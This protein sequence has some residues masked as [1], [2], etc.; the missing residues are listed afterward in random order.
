MGK[1]EAICTSPERGT[2][3]F[4]AA[5]AVLRASWGVEGDAHAGDWHRQV[6]LLAKERVDEF[7]ARGAEVSDGAFGENLLTSGLDLQALRVGA[8]LRCGPALLEIT[9]IGKDCHS[10]C[11]IYKRVGD[12]IMP[13][14]GLFARV[15]EGGP[16][17]VGDTIDVVPRDKPLPFQAAVLTASD[18][19]AAGERADESGPA[20]AARL[21][22]AGFEIVEQ[23]LLGDD[24]A[25]ISKN[26][27]RLCDQRQV[28]LIL[29]TGGTGFSPRD[30]MPEA[31]LAVMERNAPGIAEAV[32]AASVAITPRGMLSRG[33][34]VL[35]GQTLIVNL[36]GSP[37]AC[38]ECMDVILG[39]LPHALTML[40]GEGGDCAR[41]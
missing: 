3:K 20:L 6:S 35:R 32:R 13:R 31:T 27:K 1:I 38:A 14:A 23:L 2:A 8:R 17:A 11:E 36:P 29:T 19:G 24:A 28:D 15:L 18:R 4:P 25:P 26:L 40:R 34:S 22:S 12:C 7:R 41:K 16:I 39:V 21:Q 9:Q 5:R 10:H 30:Q 33:M 37:K